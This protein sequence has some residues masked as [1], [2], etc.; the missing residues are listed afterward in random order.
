MDFNKEPPTGAV[1]IQE[2][3]FSIP[4]PFA[5][6]HVCTGAEADV[7]NQ[8][9]AE[10]IRNNT[11]GRVKKAVAE[12]SFDHAL[13]QAEIDAYVKEY[14]FGVRRGRGPVDPIERE[15]LAIAK[16]EVKLAQLH[17]EFHG[18][19]L[20]HFHDGGPNLEL[21]VGE[22]DAHDLLHQVH[23]LTRVVWIPGIR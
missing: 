6:G 7:L 4:K 10:N 19:G 14:E 15:A 17:S 16:E 23:V 2:Y 5:E 12:G 20:R 13:M 22:I 8:T 11:A 3:T 9:L 18:L 1:V 21:R